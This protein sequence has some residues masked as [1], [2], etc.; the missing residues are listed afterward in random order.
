MASRVTKAK[1]PLAE[2]KAQRQASR[3]KREYPEELKAMVLQEW[4][5]QIFTLAQ[6]AARHKVPAQTIHNWIKAAG[7]TKVTATDRMRA[8]EDALTAI[9]CAGQGSLDDATAKLIAGA[10]GAA[11]IG[12]HRN[13]L[14]GL[15]LTARKLGSRILAQVEQ[16]EQIE[17]DLNAALLQ[18]EAAEDHAERER[19]RWALAQ[20]QNGALARSLRDLV[21]VQAKLI[22]MERQAYEIPASVSQDGTAPQAA[23][24]VLIPAKAPKGEPPDAAVNAG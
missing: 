23:G 11:V 7:I 12:S 5:W 6:L 9:E 17:D 1:K 4:R 21:D 24:V 18:A 8:I 19:L 22:G 13:R 2:R 14:S 16:I 10:K 3:E 15:E 20:C